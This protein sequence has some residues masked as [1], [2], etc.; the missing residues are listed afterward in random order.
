MAT[1]IIGRQ[2]TRQDLKNKYKAR[3][4]TSIDKNKKKT[5]DTSCHYGSLT[6]S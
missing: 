3:V 2:I 5:N 6:F 1:I 4:A